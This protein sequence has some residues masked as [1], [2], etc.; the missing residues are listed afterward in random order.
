MATHDIIIPHF[1]CSPDITAKA[2]RC[3]ETVREYSQDYRVIFIDN[4]TPDA[5]LA[6]ILAILKTMPHVLI[7]NRTNQGFLK[8]TNQGTHFSTAPYVIF[9]NNDAEAAPDWLEKLREPMEKDPA[10]GLVGPLTTDE[11]VQGPRGWYYKLPKERKWV[12]VP[13]GRMIAFFC[14][15]QSRRC[16]ESV[17]VHD[18]DYAKFGGFGSDDDLCLKAFRKGFHAAVR[19]DLLCPHARRTT[20]HT[21]MSKESSLDMQKQALALFHEKRKAGA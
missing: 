2:I 8:A 13:D 9:L 1:G 4:G 12:I 6:P 16:L 14:C 3:L 15:M 18:E 5:A 21:L 19:V 7:R 11:G 20:F 10:I 17:G